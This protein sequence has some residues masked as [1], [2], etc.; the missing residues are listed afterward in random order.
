MQTFLLMQR[1]DSQERM[2]AGSPHGTSPSASLDSSPSESLVRSSKRQRVSLGGSRSIGH[3]SVATAILGPH[4]FDGRSNTAYKSW[5]QA[6]QPTTATHEYASFINKKVADQE[7]GVWTTGTVQC[8]H[9]GI[10]PSM[11]RMLT[12]NSILPNK[13]QPFSIVLADDTDSICD[14]PCLLTYLDH[15]NNRHK[16]DA[17]RSPTTGRNVR[18]ACNGAAAPSSLPSSSSSSSLPQPR[19]LPRDAPA[20]APPTTG[21][22]ARFFCIP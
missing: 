20:A 4:T 11:I 3:G 1:H 12:A 19:L 15:A 9:Q 17:T 8:L 13:S 18:R 16:A 6:M 5:L 14:L 10:L 2:E 22:F 21:V 7:D